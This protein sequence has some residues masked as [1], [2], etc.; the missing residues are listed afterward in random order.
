MTTI[1]EILDTLNDE[2]RR[3][4]MFAFQHELG[5]I[6]S[7]GDGKFVGVNV[8]RIQHLSIEQRA[9]VWASGVINEDHS[10][11]APAASG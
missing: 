5:Q 11:R 9:G 8:D 2:D 6:V 4:L 7:L 1:K 3:L 10:V